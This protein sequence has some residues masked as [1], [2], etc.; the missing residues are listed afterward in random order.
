MEALELRENISQPD[1]WQ[2]LHLLTKQ[3]KY[4]PFW[5]HWGHCFLD[6]DQELTGIL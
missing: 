3:I 6:P 1:S 2:R 4:K 5:P